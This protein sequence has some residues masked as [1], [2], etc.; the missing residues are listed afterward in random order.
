MRA[1]LCAWPT[2]DQYCSHKAV[3]VDD[4]RRI[5]ERQGLANLVRYTYIRIVALDKYASMSR[6][7]EH[8]LPFIAT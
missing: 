4:A 1:L 3:D 5:R 8:L 2:A 7:M 6:E